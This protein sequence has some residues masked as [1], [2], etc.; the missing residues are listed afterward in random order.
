[1][2]RSLISQSHLWQQAAMI[3]DYFNGQFP[4]WDVPSGNHG[5]CVNHLALDICFDEYNYH[6]STMI[7]CG[8]MSYEGIGHLNLILTR[9]PSNENPLNLLLGNSLSITSALT[10]LISLMKTVADCC[11]V[12]VFLALISLAPNQWIPCLYRQAIH[13]CSDYYQGFQDCYL[14]SYSGQVWCV[15]FQASCAYSRTPELMQLVSHCL[16]GFCP[17]LSQVQSP[18]CHTHPSTN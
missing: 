7:L 4:L 11:Q 1:M 14:N 17:L 2:Y 3:M 15:H 13:C 16:S 10:S 9:C 6:V 5:S 18:V 12:F 8:C